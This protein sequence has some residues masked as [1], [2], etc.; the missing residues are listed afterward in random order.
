MS[1]NA[2]LSSAYS[3]IYRRLNLTAKYI[4]YSR[5]FWLRFLLAWFIGIAFL[6]NDYQ[7][8]FDVRFKVRGSGRS[9]DE[10]T[11]V[12][13]TDSEW[14]KLKPT[15]VDSFQ[16]IKSITGADTLTD[17]YYW[18]EYVW[19]TFLEKIL[20]LSPQKVGV[21]FFFGKNLGDVSLKTESRI[22]FN[23]HKIFWAALSD[24]EGRIQLP[25][26][27]QNNTGIIN[28]NPDSDGTVR[29]FSSPLAYIPHFGLKLSTLKDAAL[30]LPDPKNAIINFQGAAGT[31]RSV[32]MS[33]ILNE[34][35]PPE[36]FKNKIIIV[37]SKD[38]TSHLLPTPM[39]FMSKAE[40]LANIVDNSIHERWPLQL[41]IEYYFF[42]L[43]ILSLIS[44]L[45]V[46][47]YPPN[48]AL[49]MIMALSGI[50]ACLST[51]L[52]DRFYI[53]LP[54]VSSIIQILSVYI[55]FVGYKLTQNE[56]KSWHLDQERRYLFELEKLKNN[57]ISL[58]SHDLKTPIAKIQG[59]TERLMISSE[60]ETVK[61]DLHNLKSSS[62]DL[63]KYIQSI[64][65]VS[66]IESS[67][68]KV[69][70]EPRDINQIIENVIVQL[71]PLAIE[72]G[73]KIETK[74]EPLFSVEIDGPLIHEVIANLIENAIKYTPTNGSVVVS[75]DEQDNMIRVVV[76][77]TGDGIPSRELDHVW[78]KFYR[79]KKH[80]LSTKGTGLGLYLVRYFVE[81]HGGNVY[82]KSKEGAGTTIGFKLPMADANP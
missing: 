16:V 32:T 35:A 9:S 65:Q 43:A 11:L 71:S 15:P 75:S 4:W 52:F 8:N 67:D 28:L 73:I 58:I 17:N 10:I 5:P 24:S 53:W 78:E 36:W 41:S 69:N 34:T 66:R 2:S 56:R 42:Y 25:L 74:L 46:D 19:A 51:W 33:D 37:G 1:F 62:L 40:V 6:F 7:S 27:T 80:N 81:L 45:I 18:D 26:V 21:S 59:I 47:S 64:L 55:I 54:I 77:D 44:I 22:L 39:G 82:I 12:L 29:R 30:A 3:Y 48:L 14:Q 20:Q 13:I 60:N 61:T 68:F 23:N 49:A 63:Q 57:F 50:N 31:F 76:K 38:S 79:G 70:R 72:K